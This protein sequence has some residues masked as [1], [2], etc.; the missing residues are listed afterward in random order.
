MANIPPLCLPTITQ[1]NAADPA[2]EM[3]KRKN[4]TY[5]QKLEIVTP[6]DRGEMKGSVGKRFEINESTVSG[7]YQKRE[8]IKNHMKITASEAASQALHSHSQLL[9]KIQEFLECCL[10]RQAG[11]KMK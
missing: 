6:I 8:R 10:E 4:L 2:R 3:K 11:K 5:E 1:H 7:I 9:L